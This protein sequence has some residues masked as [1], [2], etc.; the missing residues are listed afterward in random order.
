MNNVLLD[1]ISYLNQTTVDSLGETDEKNIIRRFAESAIRIMGADFGFVWLN[2]KSPDTKNF[3][4]VYTSPNIPYVPKIPRPHGS[5]QKVIRTRKPLLIEDLAKSKYVRK[6]ARPY[7]TSIAIIPMVYKKNVYGSFYVCFKRKH[8]FSEEERGLAEFIGTDAGQ[9]LTIN[10][11]HKKTE[12]DS[13]KLLKQKD[14]FF[15]IAS[16]ELKTPIAAIKGFVQIL[17]QKMKKASPETSY[18]LDKINLH[19][20]KLGRLVNDLLDV[21]RIETGKLKFKKMTFELSELLEEVIDGVQVALPYHHVSFR[22]KHRFWIR[23]DRE[24]IER[25]IINLLTNAAKYSPAGSKIKVSLEEKAGCARV[26]VEDFGIGINKKDQLK[27]FKRFFQSKDNS[28]TSGLPGLGLGL[29]IA[30]EILKHHGGELQFESKE[31]SKGSIFYFLL[32]YSKYR[33]IKR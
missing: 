14:E 28:Q 16:H 19:T 12:K 7:I 11:F 21:S 9:V 29:Y 5:S 13:H 1:K 8:L 6:D 22:N 2:R 17:N 23:G 31:R 26:N 3:Q 32:P 24:H 18:F 15:N 10:T 27:I 4:L 33:I 25:V 20:E 30:R